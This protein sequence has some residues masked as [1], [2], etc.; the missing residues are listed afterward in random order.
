MR[1]NLH[2]VNIRIQAIKVLFM[3]DNVAPENIKLAE[4]GIQ[5]IEKLVTA[6]LTQDVLP[7]A[8]A[9]DDAAEIA[10]G[11]PRKMRRNIR[12][13][14]KAGQ[15]H[16]DGT[17]GRPMITNVDNLVYLVTALTIRESGR[18]SDDINIFVVRTELFD[19]INPETIE[20]AY[21]MSCYAFLVEYFENALDFEKKPLMKFLQ[22]YNNKFVTKT[23]II[24]LFEKQEWYF[25]AA[26]CKALLKID[27]EQP[28]L[29]DV[30]KE[31][32]K[33]LL[34]IKKVEQEIAEDYELNQTFD[35]A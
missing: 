23:R 30:T 1:T 24:R 7:H 2:H 32:Y 21:D 3:S 4:Q 28:K 35:K 31:F 18:K 10:G 29:L 27:S 11:N 19:F 5:D 15:E 9:I 33:K 6:I 8:V 34:D 26:Q 20:T 25:D 22:D 14:I 12:E 16:Y 13:A 17:Y